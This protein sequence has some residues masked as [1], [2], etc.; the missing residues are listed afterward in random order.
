M[1][2]S[3]WTCPA[4]M[5]T[6][7]LLPPPAPPASSSTGMYVRLALY[8]YLMNARIRIRCSVAF[9]RRDWVVFVLRRCMRGLACAP[10]GHAS[11]T[12]SQ[13]ES[14]AQSLMHGTPHF[15]VPTN[16]SLTYGVHNKPATHVRSRML[17]SSHSRGAYTRSR[18]ALSALT[19][20]S[21]RSLAKSLRSWAFPATPCLR[22][23]RPR[24][25]SAPAWLSR[26]LA[27]PPRS[28]CRCVCVRV[29]QLMQA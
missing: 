14:S 9:D 7:R 12:H 8:S 26:A 18:A 15:R 1:Q 23:R 2:P 29:H 24:T 6:R 16:S 3:S 28:P 4:P 11:G 17:T 22:M 5:R 25:S 19:T 20:T 10:A 27:L 13:S 21:S